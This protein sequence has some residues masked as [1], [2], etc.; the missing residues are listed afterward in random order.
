MSARR[1]VAGTLKMKKIRRCATSQASLAWKMILAQQTA[2]M[3][4][5]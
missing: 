3:T 4:A 2:H 1:D 5:S